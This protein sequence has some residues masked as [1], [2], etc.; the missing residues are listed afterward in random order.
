MKKIIRILTFIVV[1]CAVMVATTACGEEEST[2]IFQMDGTKIVSVTN[3]GKSFD[4]ITIPEGVTAIGENAFASC[5]TLKTLTIP[6]SVKEINAFAFNGCTALET[7]N[8]VGKEA[9]P[10][11]DENPGT[12]AVPA[13]IKDWANITFSGVASNPMQYAETFNLN[14]QAVTELNLTG[15]TAIKEKAF[16]G[17]ENLTAIKLPSNLKTIG[18]EAF[19]GCSSVTQITIPASVTA[20]GNYA[21]A[22]CDGITEV[23][24]PKNVASL[25]SNAFSDCASLTKVT[26]AKDS[27]LTQVGHYAFADCPSL[28]TVDYC[29]K[30]D[31][32]TKIVFANEFAN[33]MSSAEVFQN[34]GTTLTEIALTSATK[35]ED[36][37]FY[38][39]D[40][41]TKFTLPA[42]IRT[43]GINAF[44]NCSSLTT[45]NFLGTLDQ[46]AAI[47]FE[48]KDANPMASAEKFQTNGV[49]VTKIELKSASRVE[50]Y[51][52][53]N[54]KDATEVVIPEST[55]YFGFGAF[56]GATNITKVNYKGTEDQWAEVSFED[57]YSNPN[58]IAQNFLWNGQAKTE[59]TLKTAKKINKYVFRGFTNLTKISIP[60]SVTTIEVEAFAGC[61]AL[62]QVDFAASSGLKK[63]GP[64]AFRNCSSLTKIVIPDKVEEIMIEVFVGC[65]NLTIYSPLQK[66]DSKTAGWS[67]DWNKDNRPVVWEYVG[68]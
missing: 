42:R 38:G 35:I 43:V 56:D 47:R 66:G 16:Y 34:N 57:L 29:A 60:K 32:W 45:V 19:L 51:A 17:F 65:D 36:N 54:F 67:I 27:K 30:M 49:D 3:Y 7:V 11:T 53:H 21:F 10:A 20:I 31:N 25:G 15:M 22:Y 61:T 26:F 1:L 33:P 55:R 48:N 62:Q 68:E 64:S 13:T 12:E 39:F 58:T 28:T 6:N 37:A 8:F 40:G 14:G 50:S 41:I 24:I 52:F 63:I 4:T 59:I 44:L 9:V 2:E 5:T 18:N 46:W 23:V